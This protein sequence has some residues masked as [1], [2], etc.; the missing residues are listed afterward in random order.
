MQ[1]VYIAPYY[2]NILNSVTIKTC[3]ALILIINNLLAFDAL[4]LIRIT[5]CFL[6]KPKLIILLKLLQILAH[7]F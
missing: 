6:N 1:Y 5:D 3:V 7:Q 2:L 4:I